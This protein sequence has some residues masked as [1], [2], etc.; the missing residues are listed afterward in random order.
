MLLDYFNPSDIHG[1]MFNYQIQ[2][3][4]YQTLSSVSMPCPPLPLYIILNR[5]VFPFF[6]SKIF[7]GNQDATTP[8]TNQVSVPASLG[9]VRFLVIAPLQYASSATLSVTVRGCMQGKKS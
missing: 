3:K 8:R 9:L 4:I 1:L 7:T 5:V 2:V 6:L